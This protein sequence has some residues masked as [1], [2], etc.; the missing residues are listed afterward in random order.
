MARRKRKYD[1][2]YGKAYEG[3][4]PMEFIEDIITA[5][6]PDAACHGVWDRN[7]GSKDEDG[8]VCTDVVVTRCAP[9][10]SNRK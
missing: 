1:V 3:D 9:R 7:I 4:D 6:D 2:E 10:Y 8:N 5:T